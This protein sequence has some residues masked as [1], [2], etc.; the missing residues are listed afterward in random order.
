ME[1]G[2][3]AFAKAI[4]ITA[5]A[6]GSFVLSQQ[7]APPPAPATL[8]SAKNPHIEF[9][10]EVSRG[11]LFSRQIAEDLIF[12]LN[13]Q[14]DQG[15]GWFIEIVPKV[16]PPKGEF[17]EFTWVATPPYHFFNLRYLDTSYGTTAAQAVSRDVPRDFNFVQTLD[18]YRIAGDIV[19][20]VIYPNHATDEEMARV[21]KDAARVM[22]G[23]GALHI[24]DSRI[25]PG[26]NDKDMGSID[27]I[28]FRVELKL[29]SGQSMAQ[30]LDLDSNAPKQ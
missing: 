19:N 5:I 25:T 18:D 27:W 2:K 4:L 23:S 14:P 24:L 7:Q 10:G 13:P 16:P 22:T 29:S 30:I 11:N 17:A 21:R 8:L 9:T 28:R 15:S 3:S 6:S 1:I 12:R 26:K 20:M